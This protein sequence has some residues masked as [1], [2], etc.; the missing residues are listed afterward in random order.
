MGAAGL[1]A[2]ACG[3]GAAHQGREI[4]WNR[5]LSTDP[6]ELPVAPKVGDQCLHFAAAAE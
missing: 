5:T 4:S 6:A 3:D 1:G 2:V